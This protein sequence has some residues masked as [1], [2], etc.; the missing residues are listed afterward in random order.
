MNETKYKNEVEAHG[1]HISEV[2]QLRQ[3]KERDLSSL[4]SLEMENT[5]LRHQ[6]KQVK[7]QREKE[8]QEKRELERMLKHF[9]SLAE[10]S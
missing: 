10:S 8:G 9:K 2:K 7:R 3:E 6:I 1:I 5:Q 4:R